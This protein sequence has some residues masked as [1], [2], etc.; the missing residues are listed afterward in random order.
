MTLL[1][2]REAA[3]REQ[4]QQEHQHPQQVAAP[5][6]TGQ[7]SSASEGGKPLPR[8]SLSERSLRPSPSAAVGVGEVTNDEVAAVIGSYGRQ[9]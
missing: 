4:Q 7:E 9:Q 3:T 8:K 2:V 1:Q 5:P 6:Y